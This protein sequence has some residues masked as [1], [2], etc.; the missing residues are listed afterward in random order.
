M[1]QII[2]DVREHDEFVAEHIA[3]SISVPLS[4]FDRMAPGVLRALENKSVL[5]MCRS[6]G[7]AELALR[8]IESLGF[9][10][11]L[12][13]EV[14]VGGLLEWRRQGKPVA[15][16]QTFHLP[17]MRQ[18]QIAAGLIVLV[19]VLLGF[20]VDRRIAWAAAFVGAGLAF[21]GITGFCGLAKVLAIMPW[22][23]QGTGPG[24]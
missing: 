23:K 18:V 12:A 20:S 1:E 6:G 7:R 4:Q 13:A 17:V 5:L 2:I 11:K 15:G 8:R 22:N 10:G 3:G 24:S 16:G 9:G 21:A 19:S 14:C